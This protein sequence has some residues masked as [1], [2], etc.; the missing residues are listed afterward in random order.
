MRPAETQQ[1]ATVT[2]GHHDSSSSI[3]IP[4]FRFHTVLSVVTDRLMACHGLWIPR[5]VALFAK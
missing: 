4:D 2:A 5:V 3:F 1:E